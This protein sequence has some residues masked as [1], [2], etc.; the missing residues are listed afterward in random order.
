MS[1]KWR[2][3]RRTEARRGRSETPVSRVDTEFWRKVRELRR[4]ATQSAYVAAF[5]DIV[6][7]LRLWFSRWEFGFV[8]PPF[9]L[10]GCVAVW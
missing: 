9:S 5:W 8:Y 6:L 3:G 2:V 10:I 7:W 1:S 4:E